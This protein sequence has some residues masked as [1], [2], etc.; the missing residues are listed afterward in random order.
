MY[1]EVMK[2]SEITLRMSR[3]LVLDP[4]LRAVIPVVYTGSQTNVQFELTV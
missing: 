4:S 3:K 1:E 2:T